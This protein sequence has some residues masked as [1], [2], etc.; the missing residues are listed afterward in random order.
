[1]HYSPI[2]AADLGARFT[3]D[4]AAMQE[5]VAFLAS[6]I[7]ERR[8]TVPILSNVLIVAS[9]DGTVKVTGTDLDC[10]A[11]FTLQGQVET[12]GAFSVGAAAL[13]DFLKGAKK[14]GRDELRV[15]HADGS[16]QFK[17]G[18]CDTRMPTLPRDDFPIIMQALNQ[19]AAPLSWQ[20]DAA[21]LSAELAVIAPHISTEE[22]RYYLN[23]I[24]F[25]RDAGKLIAVATNGHGMAIV[26]REN[27]GPDIA[28]RI[29]PRKAV[30]ALRKLAKRGDAF[31]IQL[32]ETKARAVAGNVEIYCKLIDGTFPDWRRVYPAST[33]KLLIVAAD[34]LARHCKLAKPLGTGYSAKYRPLTLEL[35]GA[36]LRAGQAT[37]ATPLSG[38]YSGDDLTIGVGAV[39][40]EPVAA[41]GGN[42]SIGM[43]ASDC[44][45]TLR[46]DAMPNARWL[47][48]PFRLT[49]GLP[50]PVAVTYPAVT[51]A[52]GRAAD[53]FA[54][55]RCSD[56]GI[57]PGPR[58]ATAKEQQAYLVDYAQRCGL[59]VMDECQLVA[60]GLTFGK[61]LQGAWT[62]YH[63]VADG[64]GG[65]RDD[66]SRSP[67]AR[68]AAQYADGAYSIPMP[69]RRQ[70]PVTVEMLADDGTWSAPM[71]CTDAKGNIAMADQPKERKARA[72]KP[73]VSK[74]RRFDGKGIDPAYIGYPV[75]HETPA[76]PVVEISESPTRGGNTFDRI[77]EIARET[78]PAAFA[79]SDK[80]EIA[81]TA[82]PA[83]DL[84][85]ADAMPDVAA[86]LAR[87]DAVESAVAELPRIRM[88]AIAVRMDGP[89]SDTP[90]SVENGTEAGD[91]PNVIAW[92]GARAMHG[93]RA[94]DDAERK[95]RERAKRERLVRRY[96]AMRRERALLAGRLEAA[97]GYARKLQS[98]RDLLVEQQANARASAT[99]F[100]KGM[101]A[102][103]ERERVALKKRRR[104]VILARDLQKRL[105]AE[106][107]LVDQYAEKHRKACE[108]N[109]RLN[110]QMTAINA[111]RRRNAVLA[112][113]ARVML[114]D[115]TRELVKVIKQLDGEMAAARIT[116][117]YMDGEGR[118]GID[119]VGAVAHHARIARERGDALQSALD[120]ANQR[121]ERF[122]AALDVSAGHIEALGSR[123]ARAETAM[124]RAGVTAG[125]V[126]VAA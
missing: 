32:T 124:R 85:P 55:E 2:A 69:G 30:A 17:C 100:M 16:A 104:A 58:A 77:R 82:S 8:N 42:I 3:V 76:P 40:L 19:S 122:Q 97:N 73:K 115:A 109:R 105:N 87:L 35:H 37:Y 39:W 4:V 96:L 68:H 92:P 64:N 43:N 36:G 33:D 86:L 62:E 70:A 50:E 110:N 21:T 7:V 34:E 54:V 93:D 78:M 126:A 89:E 23:G 47:A 27:E 120:A 44:A 61:L 101:E 15:T 107:K 81:P 18:R 75:S 94:A 59:P 45:M 119:A 99:D 65:E 103:C 52:P 10:Q 49:D 84:T 106:H 111:K 66:Y 67:I 53:L 60:D 123:I 26:E 51:A 57:R 11:T 14:S 72:M 102:A 31:D 79:V 74:R 38:E 80:P 41:L 5:A 116:P 90:F 25:E 20:I 9:D 98:E 112:R 95:A 83:D 125:P 29:L 24:S 22:T 56:V 28:S 12:P 117:R 121:A 88:K 48:M 114:F 118:E 6:S 71:P 1:M 63:K 91:G 113:D 13:A 46:S 108:H